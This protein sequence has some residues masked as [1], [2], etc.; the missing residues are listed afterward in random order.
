MVAMNDEGWID[1]YAQYLACM[2][3]FV[4]CKTGGLRIRLFAVVVSAFV[5]FVCMGDQRS[6]HNNRRR[7]R[8]KGLAGNKV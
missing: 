2:G 4:F 5:S 3:P 8:M 6:I 1:N 7:P